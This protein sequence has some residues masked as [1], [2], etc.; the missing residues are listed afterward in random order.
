MANL[1]T[2]LVAPVVLILPVV[3]LYYIIKLAVKQAIKESRRD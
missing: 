1:F 2:L 3:I